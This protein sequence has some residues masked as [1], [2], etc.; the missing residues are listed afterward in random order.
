LKKSKKT[1]QLPSRGGLN[2]LGKSDRKIADYAKGTPLDLAAPTA[3]VMQNL[4]RPKPKR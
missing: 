1:R 3:G 2:D 4:A